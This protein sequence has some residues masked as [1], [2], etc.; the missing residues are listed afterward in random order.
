M[1][2][3]IWRVIFTP[4]TQTT[5]LARWMLVLGL[6]ITAC[7][8]FLAIFAPWVAPYGFSQVASH[9]TDFPKLHHPDGAHRFGTNDLLYDVLSRVIWGSRTA[10]DVVLPSV[11]IAVVMGVPLGLV[12]GYLGGWVDRI[13]VLIMDAMFAFPSLLL[14][15]VISVSLT[16]GQSSKNGGILSA[17]IAITVVYVPQYFRV[18]RNATVAAREEPYVEAARALGASPFAIMTRYIFGNVVQTV[19]VIATLNAGDAI[20][21]L[22]GLGFLGFG[23]EPSSAAEWGYELNKALSDTAAGIWWTGTFPGLAIVLL[24]VG[25]TLV[26]ESLNDVLNPLLRTTKLKQV[27]LPSAVQSSTASPASSAT[28]SSTTSSTTAATP[29]STTAGEQP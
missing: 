8:V 7:F 10:I 19:P 25:V 5:G 21:T 3:R 1:V 2:K 17:A 20:L 22:A 26:G 23:I 11:V 28:T 16:G 12:S 14:A 29:P 27:V 13:L 15:I 9:G 4:F 24:V 6:L 18:V